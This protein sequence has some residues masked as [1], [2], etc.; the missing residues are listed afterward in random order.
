MGG[1]L[2]LG[3]HL[4]GPYRKD[5]S[6]L[7]SMLSPCILGNYH[8]LGMNRHEHSRCDYVAPTRWGLHYSGSWL[9]FFLHLT[10]YYMEPQKGRAKT[11]DL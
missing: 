4:L 2:K 9:C 8:L 11:I 7:G 1:F 10:P 3:V 6:I 5:Y